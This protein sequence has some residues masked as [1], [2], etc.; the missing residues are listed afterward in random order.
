VSTYIRDNG[1]EMVEFAP[2]QAVNRQAGEALG[3]I[4]RKRADRDEAESTKE[5][6]G[7][8]QTETIGAK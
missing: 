3:L 8:N 2:H 6:A 5:R 1:D 4:A 7:P